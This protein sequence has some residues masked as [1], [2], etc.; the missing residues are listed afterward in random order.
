[1]TCNKYSEGLEILVYE[2]KFLLKK[3]KKKKKMDF[4]KSKFR[5]VASQNHHPFDRKIKDH[6]K[7]LHGLR[8]LFSKCHMYRTNKYGINARTGMI[9]KIVDL[10]KGSSKK[11]VHRAPIPIQR[12]T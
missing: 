3:K 6:S 10:T 11:M 8:G 5:V 12:I 9:T 1:M 2:R 4:V 7:I